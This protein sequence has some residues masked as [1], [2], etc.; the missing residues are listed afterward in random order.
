[1]RMRRFRDRSEAGGRLADRVPDDLQDP[2]VLALPRGGVPVAVEVAARLGAP[3]EVLVA[4]KVGA[5]GHP[6][7]GIGAI[8]EGGPLVT[9]DAIGILGVSDGELDRL[10]ARERVELERR[11]ECYRA[12]RA[13]PEI[14]GRDVVVVDDGLATG[15]TAEA[16]LHAVRAKVPRRLLLAAPVCAPDTIDRLVPPADQVIC[17]LA[18]RRFVA[19]GVW[20]D[21]FRQ[22]TDD[23]VLELLATARQGPAYRPG[24]G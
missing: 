16:A 4:R 3:L 17:V 14:A 5:P 11:V 8:A 22:L 23:D 1:M 13:L 12:G 2:L 15:V 20:Y 19:V 7:L 10:I 21:D 6:E 18:P 24:Q 9:N